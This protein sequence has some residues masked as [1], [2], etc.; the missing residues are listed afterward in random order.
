[1]NEQEDKKAFFAQYWGQCVFLTMPSEPNHDVVILKSRWIDYLYDRA[2]P[3][4][5]LKP[6]SQISDEDA[7][8][9]I[10][11][12]SVYEDKDTD[13]FVKLIVKSGTFNKYLLEVRPMWFTESIKVTDYLRSRG[14]A[15]PFRSYT[16]EQMIELGWLKLTE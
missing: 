11:L 7:I 3:C 8:E 12:S 4:L 9:V 1:M 2:L 6:L 15:L 10:K 13:E 14:Y 5:L 16:V